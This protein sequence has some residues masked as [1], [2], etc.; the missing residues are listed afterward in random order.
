MGKIR[1]RTESSIAITEYQVPGINSINDVIKWIE[2]MLK[3]SGYKSLFFKVKKLESYDDGGFSIK[4]DSI[5]EV[6]RHI[7]S[8][9]NP[10]ALKIT[11]EMTDG[12]S[13]FT[14][15]FFPDE[16]EI[17]L[18]YSTKHN[19]DIEKIENKLGLA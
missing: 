7:Y 12:D 4:C 5:D 1:E 9:D 2:S 16:S 3:N 8:S 10:E 6:K 18:L 17:H 13:S 11:C 15:L 14:I 19:V